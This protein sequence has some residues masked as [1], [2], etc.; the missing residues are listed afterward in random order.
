MTAAKP[1]IMKRH[2]A[3]LEQRYD[4]GNSPAQGVKMSAGKAVQQGVR[5][6]LAS[7]TT[8]DQL[9]KLSTEQIKE[10]DLFPAG[11]QPLP[12]PNH[13]EGGMLFPKLEI[14]EIKKQEG[15]DLTR[16]DLDFDFPDHLIPEFPPPIY[17]TTRVD[18]GDVSHGKLITM[19]NYY[20]LFNGILNPKQL[21]GLRLLVATFAATVQCHRRPALGHDG[22]A[23]HRPGPHDDLALGTALH[24][25]CGTPR[26]LSDRAAVG[27]DVSFIMPAMT[28]DC[29][30]SRAIAGASN[31]TACTR[32]GQRTG[33][34]RSTTISAHVPR[35]GLPQSSSFCAGLAA[36]D[37]FRADLSVDPPLMSPLG[38][39]FLCSAASSIPLSTACSTVF[40][41]T[42]LCV[43]FLTAF[44]IFF[45]AFF[46]P[47]FFLAIIKFLP[48]RASA[49]QYG[50]V[51]RRFLP[52][53]GFA[54]PAT[55]TFPVSRSTIIPDGNGRGN[56][57][58]FCA[59]I[60][61]QRDPRE[62]GQ[63]SR[64]SLRKAWSGERPSP[65]R[66]R[67]T[68]SAS[69]TRLVQN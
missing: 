28:G 18:L 69:F 7:G 32:A 15:R 63:D 39:A 16:F 34:L 64:T 38:S 29:R 61:A 40:F 50:I 11:F 21:E 19:D 12:H 24:P 20:E 2:M 44:S 6:K 68:Q 43:A 26:P 8:W 41:G 22:R 48:W 27:G 55:A 62:S 36:L 33:V 5:V 1:E 67:S 35:A 49:F 54:A 58:L 52:A 46:L 9:S 56:G 30:R 57:R 25:A 37:F 10:R 59:K 65:R 45:T 14:D 51:R 53:V 47:P 23:G 17:L 31:R 3:L 60:A 13:P 42:P 66:C 4:L